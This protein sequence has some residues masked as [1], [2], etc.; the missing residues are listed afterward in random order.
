MQDAGSVPRTLDTCTRSRR[1]EPLSCP[2]KRKRFVRGT[3]S[4]STA[5]GS[6]HS[7]ADRA[8]KY[9]RQRAN[10]SRLAR[11]SRA[12]RTIAHE[13]LFFAIPV[14]QLFRLAL[15]VLLFAFGEPHIEL[16]PALAVMEIERD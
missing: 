13:A 15:V 6:P 2:G 12:A 8:R 7:S 10:V 16:D 14:A 9:D 1:S 5:H 4:A 3:K 11:R